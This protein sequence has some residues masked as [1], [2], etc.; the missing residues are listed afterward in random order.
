[1]LKCLRE[2]HSITFVFIYTEYIIYNKKICLK[3]KLSIGVTK[4]WLE[5]KIK[6]LSLCPNS[7][8]SLSIVFIFHWTRSKRRTIW[9]LFATWPF[10]LWL[11]KLIVIGTVSSKF[12][13]QLLCH[14]IFHDFPGVTHLLLH[15]VGHYFKLCAKSNVDESE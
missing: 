12:S 5:H 4:N 10:K 14:Y 15:K 1:M 13:G 7:R 2:F 8:W 11:F 9:K 6:E 3:V